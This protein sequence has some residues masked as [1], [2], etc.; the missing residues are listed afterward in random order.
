MEPVA[1]A[2]Q[3][4]RPR[5]LYIAGTGRSGSTLIGNMLGSIPGLCSV[6]EMRYLWERG[7]GEHAPCG[8]G[9]AVPECPFWKKVL[10]IAYPVEMVDSSSVV[11]ADSAL[12]RLRRLPAL[13]RARGRADASGEVAQRYLAD[14]VAAYRAV[15]VVTGGHVVVDASKLMGFGYLLARSGQLDVFVLHLVRDPRGAAYSWGRQRARHDRGSGANAMA[16]ETPLASGAFWTLWNLATERLR[17]AADGR[18]VRVRYEDVV[19]DPRAALA[20][21]LDLFGMA[22]HALPVLADG[23]VDLRP[24]HTVAGNPN[25]MRSGPTALRADLEWHT[26]LRRRDKAV[27]TL[28]TAPLLRR[29]GYRFR[30]PRPTPPSAGAAVATAATTPP[31]V[32]VEDLNGVR[33]L[34]ARI[35]RNVTWAR[36]QGFRRVLEEKEIDPLRT[37]P[38]AVR[39]WNY[40]RSSPVPPGAAKPVY[41]IGLQRSGTNMLV[42]GLGLAPEVEVHNE[43]DESAFHHYK[44]RP[45][46]VV[47]A[48]VG[49]SRHELVL[50][51]PLCDSH[52]ADHLLDNLNTITPGRALWAYRNV[53]GR[54]RSALAKFS[55]GNLQ[56]LREFAAGTNTTRWH[57]ARISTESADLVRS[58][59]YDTMTPAS[60]AALMWL[61]RNR[62][63][64]D[65]E[66]DLRDDVRLVSYDAFL[67]DPESTMGNL[68]RF[69]DFPYGP[70]LA[71][72]A[73]A[74]PATYRGP[75]DIDPLIRAECT[76]LGKELDAV[77]R[78]Q[79][80]L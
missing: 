40:R 39:K 41:V 73:L 4:A 2:P 43:N 28:A 18:Y 80:G 11:A 27:V 33:R 72:H 76:Q 24:N 70:A 71:E 19:A 78:A 36:E 38:S 59:D 45:D 14:V 23:S 54:V 49:R 79:S 60:G 42:R 47:E 30:V 3:P 67:E 8:C 31:R 37:W 46:P 20:P 74:R 64:F 10:D 13:L 56:V 50:F 15:D 65:L 62:L 48:I 57:T 58:F 75:L 35:E 61:V 32:F 52:R 34:Q 69:L 12:L 25:R 21:V 55:D 16:Q 68:C 51:K 9:L 63:F 5:V 29:Y 7:I 26:H 77:A 44:L 17:R 22:A 1:T 53:D 6:G 66:L